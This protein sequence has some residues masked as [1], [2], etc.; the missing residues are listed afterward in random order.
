MLD[1]LS[2]EF[3]LTAMSDLVTFWLAMGGNLALTEP[4]VGLCTESILDLFTTMSQ[5]ELVSLLRR[6]SPAELITTTQ[7]TLLAHCLNS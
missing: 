2:N 4:L 5:D 7:A 3:Q 6:P 1:Q